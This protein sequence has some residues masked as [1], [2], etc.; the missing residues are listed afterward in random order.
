LGHGLRN[1]GG[2]AYICGICLANTLAAASTSHLS[3]APPKPSPPPAGGKPPPPPDSGK[4]EPA[5][6]TG[7]AQLAA[8][9]NDPRDLIDDYD[10]QRWASVRQGADYL[11]RALGG[12]DMP[13]E[14]RVFA[15]AGLE[16]SRVLMGAAV[17]I[18][19]E[20]G[21]STEEMIT[22]LQ[23]VVEVFLSVRR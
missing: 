7:Y 1:R 12:P 4:R 22:Q 14:L 17:A 11:A 2:P 21:L 19:T 20:L 6:A 13:Q 3:T 9:I 15:S 23:P 8:G 5:T 18:A 10:E 16:R